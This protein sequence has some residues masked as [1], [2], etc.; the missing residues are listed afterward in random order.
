MSDPPIRRDEDLRGYDIAAAIA[1]G[2]TAAGQAR[3]TLFTAAAIAASLCAEER[4]VGPYPLAF[5]A[6]CVRSLGLDG[7]LALPEPLIGEQPTELVRS[8][9]SA[10]RPEHGADVARDDLFAQWLDVV[11]LVLAARRSVRSTGST[12]PARHPEQ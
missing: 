11:A 12:A 1:E 9:M 6:G 8:W 3:T 2:T 4:G 5:L 7:A 10:A